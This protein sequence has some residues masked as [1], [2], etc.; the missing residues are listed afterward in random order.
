MTAVSIPYKR[1]TN[2]GVIEKVNVSSEV[3]IPYKRVT[4]KKK[5]RPSGLKYTGFNPL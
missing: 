3:S 5:S 4:N 2:Q 1:V